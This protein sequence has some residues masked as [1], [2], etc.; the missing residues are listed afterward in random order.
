MPSLNF[1]L[2]HWLYWSMLIGLPLIA[3]GVIRYGTK[4]ELANRTTLPIAYFLWLVGGLVGL[5]RFYLRSALGAVFV[6]LFIAVLVGNVHIR[7]ADNVVSAAHNEQRIADYEIERANKRIA[8]EEHGGAE[9]LEKAQAK[10]RAAA[11]QQLAAQEQLADARLFVRLTAGLIAALLLIDLVLLPRL[12][13]RCLAKEAAAPKSKPL[14]EQV[15]VE[16]EQP[17]EP[18][19][20][21]QNRFTNM[22]DSLNGFIGVF[23]AYWSILAV[24]VYY[25]EVVARYVFN[26]PTNWAHESMFLMF[27][28]QYLLAGGY[29]LKENHHVRV[30][31]F[32]MHFSERRKA[33]TDVIT[34]VF[35]FIF[36][37]VMLWTG[38]T[39]FNDSFRVQ[40]VSFTEWA[41]QYWPIKAAIPLGALLLLLQGIVM[42]YRDIAVLLEKPR[43]PAAG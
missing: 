43:A 30:D 14:I 13:R 31:V 42:L 3:M 35:F 38:W 19:H 41:I 12:Y 4:H 16:P 6:P 37:G 7:T 29:V 18:G 9:A 33:L 23:V 20:R 15:H 36:A 1:V 21:I 22:V 25:Y 40:E 39:F 32:Y 34:S 10:Q 8:N 11:A 5:H 27:G 28:M 24:F 2:P 26:S 17:R